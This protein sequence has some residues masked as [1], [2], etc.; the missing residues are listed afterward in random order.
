MRIQ[1]PFVKQEVIATIIQTMEKPTESQKLPL[2][3]DIEIVRQT[4][5]TTDTF[6][7]IWKDFEELRNIKNDIFFSSITDKA[8][9]LFK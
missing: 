4:N 7:E 9:E 5:F 8:K 1:I 3:I 6:S 2:I